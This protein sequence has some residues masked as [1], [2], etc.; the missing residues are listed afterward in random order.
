MQ[1]LEPPE[2]PLEMVPQAMSKVES[3]ATVSEPKKEGFLKKLFSKKDK[4]ALSTESD[5]K[6]FR[7]SDLSKIDLP[8]LD[9]PSP[10]PNGYDL[11]S[12]GNVT[13]LPII[14]TV[15]AQFEDFKKNLDVLGSGK[16]K[17]KSKGNLKK[18]QSRN[19]NKIDE[20]S[21]FDWEREVKDQEILIHDSSRYNQDVNILISQADKHVEDK[22]SAT[23]NNI[24]VSQHKDIDSSP[25]FFD[26]KEPNINLEQPILNSNN[27]LPLVD[28]EQSKNFMKISM[29]HQ[30][31]KS[32]LEK[33][34][35]NK[36]LFNNRAKMLA[37][38]K[39][40]DENVEK[41]IEDKELEL[42]RKKQ[43]IEKYEKHLKEQEKEILNTHSYIKS[44]DTKLSDREENINSLIAK[45]AE[46][47]LSRRLKIDKKALSE[48]LDKT[49]KLNT[50]LKKKTKIIDDDR[51]RFEQEHQ[52]LSEMERKK[53]TELQGVYEKKLKELDSERKVFEEEKITF[54]EKRKNLLAL[55]GRADTVSRD[56]EDIKK[57]KEYIDSSKS[58]VES[59]LTEDKE[60]KSAIEKAEKSL[61]QEKENLDKMIFDKYLN[62]NLKNIKPEYMQTRQE[63]KIALRNNPLFDQI[64]QCRKLLIQR[65]IIG[66]KKL[67][68]DIRKAYDEV[69]APAKEKEALYTSIRELYNDIQLRFVEAQ[70]HTG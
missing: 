57:T 69:E 26:I 23:S 13:D 10:E 62:N 30:R 68:N 24:F 46:S 61:V 42:T 17:N 29:S 25:K 58:F 1:D 9:L 15:T 35:K 18:G 31:L 41:K 11:D 40:Y 7:E 44:L 16:I 48:E 65:N 2:V 6:E 52:R 5:V 8:P 19:I 22:T 12:S 33:Y 43:Q 47:E 32:T 50:D 3:Q 28:E 51:I 55:V 66:A 53:L 34:L 37:L 67:Y 21:K 27:E 60:L 45:T 70:I 14:P 56:L 64:S 20:S 39:L 63:W 4:Q 59:E 36:K 38:F 49:K 54:A